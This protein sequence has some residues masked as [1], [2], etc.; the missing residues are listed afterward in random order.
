L[1]GGKLRCR[2]DDRFVLDMGSRFLYRLL[3]MVGPRYFPVRL[4]VD[5][6]EVAG[7]VIVNV[8]DEDNEGSYLL[9]GDLGRKLF[10]GRFDEICLSLRS[11]HPIP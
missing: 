3:G 9:H 2:D 6:Q 7:T 11:P 1:L 8:T 10:V 4:T 5:L